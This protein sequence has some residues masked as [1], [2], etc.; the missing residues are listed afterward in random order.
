MDGAV[1][2]AP[3]QESIKTPVLRPEAYCDKTAT[4]KAKSMSFR[5][6]L[7][8]RLWHPRKGQKDARPAGRCTELERYQTR[9]LV[10]Q[11]NEDVSAPSIVGTASE[12]WAWP[13]LVTH[14]FGAICLHTRTRERHVPPELARAVLCGGVT[15]APRQLLDTTGSR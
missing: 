8:Q 5:T 14:L 7:L 3:S 12:P 9:M 1:C 11:R 6:S 13:C 10:C 15:N 4:S 2:D